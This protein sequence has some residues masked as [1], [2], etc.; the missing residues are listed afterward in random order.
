M[1]LTQLIFSAPERALG[2]IRRA[3]AQA[4]VP[5]GTAAQARLV[6]A[7]DQMEELFTTEAEP[8]SR[9]AL[10]RALD[11]LAGSGL[12]WVIGTIR[13]D[14]FHR[15][16]EIPGFSE[17]KDGLGSFELLPPTGPEIAQIIRE[18]ARSAGL[19]FE[20]DQDQGRLEDVLQDAAVADAGSLPLLEFVLDGLFQAGRER[21]LLTF[22]A[23]RALG[24]LAGAIARRADELVGAL[25]QDVQD[26]LPAVLRALMTVR[27]E[28]A[29]TARPAL[30]SQVAGRPKQ[31]ALVDAMVEARLLVIDENAS[32]DP[33]VRLAHEALLTRWPRAQTIA[34][35]N[36]NFLETRARVQADA[37]RWLLDNKNPDLLLPPGKRLAESEELLVSRREEVEDQI[38]QYIEA[39]IQAQQA[40]LEKERLAERE[41]IESEEAAKRERLRARGR[42]ARPG[43]GGRDTPCT[44]HAIRGFDIASSSHP[45]RHRCDRRVPW[46]TRGKTAGSNS[47][48]PMQTKPTPQSRTPLARAIKRCAI[49]RFLLPSYL[50]RPLATGDTETA[51]L[52]ALEALP[53]DFAAPDRPYVKEAEI[54]LYRALLAHCQTMVFRQDGGVTYAAFNATGDRIVT[55]SYDKTARI[56]N[57]ANGSEIAVLKGHEGAV[58]KAIFSL[59][60]RRIATAGRDGTA[61]IWDASSGQQILVLPQPGNVHTAMFNAAG[62]RV[63]TGSDRQG[64][65]GLGCSDWKKDR[66]CRRRWNNIRGV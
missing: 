23:Y 49:N 57:S 32:G 54:V 50:N 65:D 7:V 43:G 17:L 20:E 26:A 48:R 12:V 45:G 18:P 35:A 42:T 61:R 24:G 14:F 8:A 13:A 22:A 63:L 21:R 59:D 37:R 2:L 3:L 58:E 19:R 36:R 16:S 33:V 60:G 1:D 44:A 6:I 31:K 25:P 47:Q 66:D 10:V 4:A 52:L 34:N 55:S 62:T 56:W 28:E 41:R 5:Q 40:R 64:F 15:C 29:I 53:K 30:L 51:I 27:D 11:M 38:V 39:S 9:E 46:A